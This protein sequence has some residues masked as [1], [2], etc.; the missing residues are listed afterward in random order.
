MPQCPWRTDLPGPPHYL[1]HTTIVRH[2]LAW[3]YRNGWRDI[4]GPSHGN[5]SPS[6][7]TTATQEGADAHVQTCNTDIM[8]VDVGEDGGLPHIGKFIHLINL[9]Y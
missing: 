1:T 3:E 4:D 2:K 5:I 9:F 7:A 8:D 6:N